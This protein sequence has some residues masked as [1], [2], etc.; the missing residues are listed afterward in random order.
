MKIFSAEPGACQL[1]S[2]YVLGP[3]EGGGVE[4]PSALLCTLYTPLG[5]IYYYVNETIG[6]LVNREFH[7]LD[8]NVLDIRQFK[9]WLCIGMFSIYGR[10][11]WNWIYLTSI[12][13]WSVQLILFEGGWVIDANVRRNLCYLICLRQFLDHEQSRIRFFFS[14]KPTRSE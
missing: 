4:R 6:N 2:V 3:Q 11:L 9:W 5:R 13:Y 7:F 10:G 12:F 1:N 14:D 8:Y